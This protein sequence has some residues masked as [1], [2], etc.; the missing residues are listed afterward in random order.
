MKLIIL[1]ALSALLCGCEDKAA[2]RRRQLERDSEKIYFSAGVSLGRLVHHFES[3]PSAEALTERAW[4]LW[5]NSQAKGE[6][7][8][9]A[10]WTN[11]APAGFHRTNL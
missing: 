10:H 2:E 5:T 9:P 4:C 3:P 11:Q 1:I 6:A 8:L 7:T